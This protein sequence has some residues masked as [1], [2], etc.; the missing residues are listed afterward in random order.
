MGAA[1]ARV[2][3]AI[4]GPRLRTMPVELASPVM[5]IPLWRTVAVSFE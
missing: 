2:T 5:V 4:P 3:V 1:P